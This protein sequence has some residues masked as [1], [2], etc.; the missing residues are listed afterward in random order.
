M[1][2]QTPVRVKFM[3]RR[4]LD[5]SF[6]KTSNDLPRANLCRWL[7]ADGTHLT[8]VPREQAWGFIL[9]TRRMWSAAA[10][11]EEDNRVLVWL[12]AVTPGGHRPGKEAGCQRDLTAGCGVSQEAREVT[13]DSLWPEGFNIIIRL[14]IPGL[15]GEKLNPDRESWY[16]SYLGTAPALKKIKMRRVAVASSEHSQAACAGSVPRRPMWEHSPRLE[17]HGPWGPPN[18]RQAGPTPWLE[19]G[20][21]TLHPVRAPSTCRAST[22]LRR[23]DTTGTSPPPALYG[24]LSYRAYDTIKMNFLIDFFACLAGTYKLSSVYYKSQ[25]IISIFC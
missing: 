2:L 24:R 18:P 3:I 25:T 20:F 16:K 14:K 4:G 11:L 12:P 13:E 21:S 17:V 7:C 22:Q 5:S 19:A 1:I 8:S 10:F 15:T 9:S 6:H 23:R